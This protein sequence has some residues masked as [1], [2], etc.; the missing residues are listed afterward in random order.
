[1][2]SSTRRESLGARLFVGLALARTSGRAAAGALARSVIAYAV[3]NARTPA[4][5][6]ATD[7]AK[8]ARP[9]ARVE[10]GGGDENGAVRTEGTPMARTSSAMSSRVPRERSSMTPELSSDARAK[11]VRGSIEGA[12]FRMTGSPSWP[13]GGPCVS[14][15][16]E[17]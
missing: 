16:E 1:M 8:S 9:R 6:N 12:L 2:A 4:R 3:A 15:T 7:A 13:L 5:K 10:A 17:V 11:R 14:R